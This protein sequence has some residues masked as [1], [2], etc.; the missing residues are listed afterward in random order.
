M[1]EVQ[2][3]LRSDPTFRLQMPPICPPDIK[4]I[5][6]HMWSSD[7]LKRPSAKAV[8]AKLSPY[9]NRE[10]Y[11]KIP[12]I[13]AALLDELSKKKKRK[14]QK[15][16]ASTT[17]GTKEAS[18]SKEQPVSKEFPPPA[19]APAQ[20]VRLGKPPSVKKKAPASLKNRQSGSRKSKKNTTVDSKERPPSVKKRSARSN[21]K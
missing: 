5:A 10:R 4:N 8:H 17:G 9:A 1:A 11:L 20:V 2:T 14:S 13:D 15:S 3:K 18:V 19:R 7:P 16:R 12:G 6:R 21:R